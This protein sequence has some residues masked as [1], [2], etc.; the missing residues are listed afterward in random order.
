MS[1][2]GV[3]LS[4]VEILREPQYPLQAGTDTYQF[5]YIRVGSKFGLTV[6]QPLSTPPDVHGFESL[7]PSGCEARL[8]EMIGCN[9]KDK[10]YIYGI[11][12]PFGHGFLFVSY[13]KGVIKYLAWER[14]IISISL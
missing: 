4:L 10:G 6:G 9:S 13:D 5:G 1:I 3:V 2:L 14:I 12:K 7:G 11:N 8:V